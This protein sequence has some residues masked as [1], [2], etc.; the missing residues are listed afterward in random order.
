MSVPS[1]AQIH[2]F[3]FLGSA[4]AQYDIQQ[5][6]VHCTARY[7]TCHV[8]KSCKIHDIRRSYT[9]SGCEKWERGTRGVLTRK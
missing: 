9:I 5:V 4:V 3:I 6:C 2:F 8:Y 7:N 1:R